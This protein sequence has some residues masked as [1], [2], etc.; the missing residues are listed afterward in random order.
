MRQQH[1][2]RTSVAAQLPGFGSHETRL[3]WEDADPWIVIPCP[4]CGQEQLFVPTHEGPG[5]AQCSK[6]G[7]T[8]E[9]RTLPVDDKLALITAVERA[10]AEYEY[11][12]GGGFGWGYRR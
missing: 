4:N 2:E 8:V 12:C 7:Y 9:R 6:C 10:W 11:E 1:P 3:E 5:S